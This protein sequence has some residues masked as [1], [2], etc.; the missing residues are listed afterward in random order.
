MDNKF[1]YRLGSPTNRLGRPP[2]FYRSNDL[3]ARGCTFASVYAVREEDA[4][5]IQETA[6]TAAG[7]K[8]IVWSQRLW[9][10]FD[11]ARAGVAAQLK[12]KEE[13]IDHVVFTTGGRGYH[14]GVGRDASPSHTLPLQDKQWVEENLQGADLS[15]YWHLHLI[16]LP[17]TTHERTGLPKRLLYSHAGRDITLSPYNP[18]EERATD[19]VLAT[20]S[21][22]SLFMNWEI[23][24]RLTP[25]P[26][27]RHHQLVKLAKAI[28]QH[29]GASMDEAR[30]VLNELNRSFKEPKSQ[31]EVD[32]IVKWAYN[33]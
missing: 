26:G 15:L 8:G 1:I 21:R 9:V 12:L 30:W 3:I 33:G 18:S 16:R 7:F 5:C 28:Q 13:G 14:I 17:G 31:E 23:M 2:Q 20:T 4:I 11:D 19:V 10:D 27:N 25:N 32:K 6:Q 29:G 22:P 24:T